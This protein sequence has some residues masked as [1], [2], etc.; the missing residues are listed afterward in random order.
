M[1]SPL[2]STEVFNSDS[3]FVTFIKFPSVCT[4]CPHLL[5]I[6]MHLLSTPALPTHQLTVS[7]T[8]SALH[9]L[10]ISWSVT[11]SQ[12]VT[13]YMVF[14][15]KGSAVIGK[16]DALNDIMFTI[17]NL[18]SNTAYHVVVQA[19]GLLGSVNST[20]KVFYTTPNTVQGKFTKHC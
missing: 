2:S 3:N 1:N 15:L 16:S 7:L 8:K 4:C 13:S 11:S 5:F 19:N 17:E 20:S 9:S 14:W 6:A 18:L 10:A 12:D